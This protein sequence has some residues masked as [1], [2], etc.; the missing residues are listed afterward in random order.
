MDL[1]SIKFIFLGLVGFLVALVVVLLGYNIIS[2]LRKPKKV[3]I[4]PDFDDLEKEVK[5]EKAKHYAKQQLDFDGNNEKFDYIKEQI[6]SINFLETTPMQAFNLL[7][8]IQ[9]KLNED[10]K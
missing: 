9:Q 3:S 6:G 1:E 4:L 10:V 8:E 5:E 7:Y 2:S